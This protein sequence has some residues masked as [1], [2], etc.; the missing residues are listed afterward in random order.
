M[1]K[2]MPLVRTASSVTAWLAAM[3]LGL[4]EALSPLV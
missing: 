4:S 3:G 2:G 1:V